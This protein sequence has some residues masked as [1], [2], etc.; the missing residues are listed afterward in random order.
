MQRNWR[1]APL[2]LGLALSG[3]ASTHAES[4]CPLAVSYQGVTYY[5]MKTEAPVDGG[6]MLGKVGLSPCDDGHGGDDTTPTFE[7]L[8]IAGID[9]SV[10]IVVPALEQP[11][12]FYN[13]PMNGRGFPPQVRAL[14]NH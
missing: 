12:L 2:V 11:Y 7:A 4:T 13:G 14:L 10:A 1:F 8:S 6:A 3:C 9:P 5:A